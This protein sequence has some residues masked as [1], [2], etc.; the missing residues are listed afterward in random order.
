MSVL[1]NE[2]EYFKSKN[3]NNKLNKTGFNFVEFDLENDEKSLVVFGSPIAYHKNG[4]FNEINL[5]I[6]D[7]GSIYAMRE[8]LYEA[9]FSKDI[10]PKIKY[11]VNN[12]SVT[13]IPICLQFINELNETETISDFISGSSPVLSGNTIIWENSFGNGIHLKYTTNPT[14]LHKDLIIDSF[15]NLPEPTITG[16]IRIEI[17]LEVSG[18]LKLEEHKSLDFKN[19]QKEKI[20]I[21]KAKHDNVLD[22]DLVFD[23]PRYKDSG[24]QVVPNIDDEYFETIGKRRIFEEDK[25]VFITTS[26]EYSWL[27][28]A[29]YPVFI[30]VDVDYQVGYTSD[31]GD[32]LGA[33][34][35]Y[36]NKLIRAGHLYAPPYVDASTSCCFRF[37]SVAIPQGATI[38]SA[39]F[40]FY[41]DV[42]G[43]QTSILHG[44]DEDDTAGM[45]SSPFGR[46]KTTAS[47][48]F[49]YDQWTTYTTGA[50]RDSP[51]VS[52]VVQE[53]VNRAG[54]ASGNDMG[55]LWEDD[56]SSQ[57][58][59][60]E[61]RSYNYSGNVSGPKFYVTY[62]PA[63]S[64]FVIAPLASTSSID[65]IVLSQAG[66]TLSIDALASTSSE[67]NIVLAQAGGTLGIAALE[68]LSEIDNITLIFQ[69]NFAIDSL[70]SSSEIDDLVLALNSGEFSTDALAST[71][72]IG[73][74]FLTEEGLFEISSIDSVSTID[75]ITLI[76]ASGEFIIDGL[77]SLSEIDNITLIFQ[78][79]FAID[80]LESISEIGNVVVA[81]NSGEF[82]IDSMES[83]TEIDNITLIFQGTFSIDSMDSLANIDDITLIQASGT[84]Q[85]AGLESLSEIENIVLNQ[86]I[87]YLKKMNVSI[88]PSRLR[89]SISKTELNAS[90]VTSKLKVSIN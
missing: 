23:L 3:I 82:V 21:A 4:K 41:L 10:I 39:K 90:I 26:V 1:R 60:V 78:G 85:I 32:L 48:D 37:N 38:S 65:S 16:E 62:S 42:A 56:S 59:N 17:V 71:S 73:N 9:E 28:M 7:E 75:N 51:S 40:Q 25:K 43:N 14:L 2:I 5:D 13:F 80:S 30:D 44:I 52:S 61:A 47:S 89:I 29:L 18:S 20:V 6:I 54:W 55:F 36:V 84:L 67:D 50:F 45:A 64:D 8:S 81:L 53:I 19:I 33:T 12:K 11:T 70:E 76:Q 87:S 58:I 74:I 22:G 69:G 35:N 66:G 68:S 83:Q 77:E 27:K 72:S 86:N 46:D 24:I 49:S 88:S 57:G 34:Y 31:N 15:G 63:S 79:N